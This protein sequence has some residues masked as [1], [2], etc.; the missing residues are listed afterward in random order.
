VTLI[1]DASVALKWFMQ[2]PGS[3][4]A[5]RILDGD[6]PLSAPDLIIV[7]A[8]NG[9]WKAVRQQ[10]M[11]AVQADWMARRL[12]LLFTALHPAEGLALRAMQIARHLD[13]PVYDCFY[14]AL[15]EQRDAT[16]VTADQ[17]FV[18]RVSGTRWQ[19]R[20][21]ALAEYGVAP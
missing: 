3:E 10:L 7:E 17:R 13:H 18:A 15:A 16:M 6:A 20:V 14:L 5:R 11:T 2:E 19:G 4:V 9:A 21:K 12:P 8:C 1:I